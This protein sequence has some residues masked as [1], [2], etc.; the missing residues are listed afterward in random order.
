MIIFYFSVI[1]IFLLILGILYISILYYKNNLRKVWPIHVLR[2]IISFITKPLF[3]PILSILM[4]IL[5]CKDGKNYFND[6]ITCEKNW[7]I[8]LRSLLSIISS[9]LFIFETFLIEKIFF[10]T[11]I[12]NNNPM[13]K[14]TSE[15]DIYFLLSKILLIIVFTF[16]NNEN[17]K[18]FLVMV[19]FSMS[20]LNLFIFISMSPYYDKR[21][22]KVYGILFTIFFW[23]NT[24][25]LWGK[26]FE[27][28]NFDGCIGLF[29]IGIP[30]FIILIISNDKMFEGNI[31]FSLNKINSG[32]QAIKIIKELLYLIDTKDFIRSSKLM[33]TSYINQYEERCIESDCPIK[34]YLSTLENNKIDAPVFL[35]QHCEDVYQNSISKFPLETKL[36]IS[37]AFFLMDRLNKK[38]QASNEL[39]IASNYPM[40]FEEEFIIF[41]YKKILEEYIASDGEDDENLDIVSNLEYTNYYKSFKNSIMKVSSLYIDFWTLL[42]NPNQD[43]HEDLTH[44]NDYGAEINKLVEDINLSFEKMQKFKVNDPEVINYYSDF[45]SDILNDKEKSDKYKKLLQETEIIVQTNTD[46]EK[47]K[48]LNIETLLLNDEYHYIIVSAK[49]EKFGIITNISLGICP[50]FGYSKNEIIGKTIEFLMPDIYQKKHREVL[51]EKLKEFKKNLFSTS[52]QKVTY[53]EIY[54]FGKNKSKYLIQIN[55]KPSLIQ[56]ETDENIFISRLWQDKCSFSSSAKSTCFLITNNLLKIQYF[57]PNAITLLGISSNMINSNIEI[58]E[59]IKQFYEE[60]LKYILDHQQH[61]PEEKMQLKRIILIKKFKNPVIINWKR[62]ENI[63]HSPTNEQQTTSEVNDFKNHIFNL[64]KSTPNVSNHPMAN[65]SSF[66]GLNQKKQAL[67]TKTLTTSVIKKY[68][69]PNQITPNKRNNSNVVNLNNNININNHNNNTNIIT[70]LDDVFMLTVSIAK[71]K[72]NH[73]GFIFKF[74]SFKYKTKTNIGTS[75]FNSFIMSQRKRDIDHHVKKKESTETL[76]YFTKGQN[77]SKNYYDFK[78]KSINESITPKEGEISNF[79]NIFKVDKNYI[80]ESKNI[81]QLDF[82]NMCFKIKN[83]DES[84]RDYLKEEAIKKLQN[85]TTSIENEEEEEE[86]SESVENDISNISSSLNSSERNPISKRDKE[87]TKVNLEN[88]G[89][90]LRND[91]YYR[92]NLSP[93][94]YSIYDYVKLMVVDVPDYKK[95]SQ[96]ELKMS[97]EKENEILKQTPNNQQGKTT[98]VRTD[99]TKFVNVDSLD[100]KINQT[101]I[102]KQIEY[103]LGK[104]ETQPSI[105][106]LRIISFIVFIILISIGLSLL[107]TILYCHKIIKENIILII[108]SYDL[109]AYNCLGIYYSKELVLLNNEN[110][111]KFPYDNRE[112]YINNILNQTLTIFIKEHELIT[113]I[114]SSFLKISSKNYKYLSVDTIKTYII[115]DDFNITCYN[116]VLDNS[117]IEANSALFHIGHKNISEIIPTNF[118]VFYYIYNSMNDIFIAYEKHAQTYLDE[119]N[120]K[121]HDLEIILIVVVIIS[122]L[123]NVLCYFLISFAYDLIAQ[124]K[125]SYLEVFFEIGT[126]V[127]RSSLEKCEKFIKKINEE[128]NNDNESTDS[129]DNEIISSENHINQ[130]EKRNKEKGKRGVRKTNSSRETK[131][132]KIIMALFFFAV[133]VFACIIFIYD[134]IWLDDSKIFML[135]YQKVTGLKNRYIMIFNTLREFMFDYNIKVNSTNSLTF[136]NKILDNLYIVNTEYLRYITE[137]RNIIPGGFKKKYEEIL[138]TN[139]CKYSNYFKNENDCMN[140]M[141]KSPS[142]G[143]SVVS[144][145]FLEN[146]RIIKDSVQKRIKHQKLSN[147]TFNLTLTGTKEGKKLWPQGEDNQKIYQELDSIQEFLID[148]NHLNTN[149]L[150]IHLII[151]YINVLSNNLSGAILKGLK[152]NKL[153]YIILTCFYIAVMISIYIFIWLPFQTNLSQTIFKTKNMLT[154]IPK[155]V[156]SELSNIHKLLDL[157]QKNIKGSTKN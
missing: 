152:N 41:R 102:I 86:E 44:L 136:L 46:K 99:I 17:N 32:I 130:N 95:I 144:S 85:N 15:S 26:I 108:N 60:F 87:K 84:I 28:T 140:F 45:L 1:S 110:Y 80:P 113:Y 16:W 121:I 93:I 12:S 40:S 9:L 150:F 137:K 74:E 58:T 52:E 97:G 36:R 39:A 88:S 51:K 63:N 132:F 120:Y 155:E 73:E 143:I 156:L 55:L 49:P 2:E 142:F 153:L 38:K 21:I 23:T 145:Y 4:S 65:N 124:R 83:D 112:E 151:P 105:V 92:V 96:V 50:I 89:I 31:L 18:W 68:P 115:E 11:Q 106:R 135:C 107:Y 116:M 6:K 119:I 70:N 141:S 57:T 48:I 126:P 7:K 100:S 53:N 64:R 127:I 59:F 111:T 125:E 30:I 77:F 103:S 139:P 81:F 128:N 10:E 54:T 104:E 122:I 19:L 117:F 56:T 62:P 157:G 131:V 75:I 149:I 33:L 71:I 14:F 34:K 82:K 43:I 67:I 29:T 25:L 37:Y 66:I 35:V 42:L 118:Y 134:F 146:V 91:E 98:I 22:I 76:A 114:I 133:S 69:T 78:E 138:L 90:K 101:I 47:N 79:S 24:V 8:Y 61:T 148:D 147:F 154:I 20:L 109:L 13:A 3:I 129:F 27:N 72:N 123:M 94:K 5:N